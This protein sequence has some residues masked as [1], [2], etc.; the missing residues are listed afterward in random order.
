MSKNRQ[1]QPKAGLDPP[2]TSDNKMIKQR[3]KKSKWLKLS[4]AKDQ[5]LN[6]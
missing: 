3:W 6:T 2:R 5:E 1:S 4:Q